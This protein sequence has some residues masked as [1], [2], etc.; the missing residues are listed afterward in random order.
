MYRCRVRNICSLWLIAPALAVGFSGGQPASTLAPAS[1]RPKVAGVR[2]SSPDQ[3]DILA[4]Q[5]SP[6]YHQAQTACR[7]HDFHKAADLLKTL[8]ASP[9]FTQDQIA[10]CQQQRDLCLKDASPLPTSSTNA[11][12]APSASPRDADCGPRALLFVY[13]KLGVKTTLE[14]VRKAAGTTAEGT[15]MAG[16]EKAV[17]TA[18]WKAEGVQVSRE[19]LPDT[20]MPAIAW[21]NRNHYVALLELKGSGE[22]GQAVIHDPNQPHEETISQEKLLQLTGGY[23]LLIHR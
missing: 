1:S 10:F 23:L 21:V 17:K 7:A 13:R 8:S 20:Q 2:L 18:G 15:S 14:E 3:S 9:G 16:L 4:V 22:T 19:A 11:A 6:L 12:P 5:A